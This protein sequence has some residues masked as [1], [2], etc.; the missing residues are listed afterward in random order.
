M[1]ALER[2]QV[3][4]AVAAELLRLGKEL[5]LRLAAVEEGQLVAARERCLGDGAAEEGRPAEDQKADSASSRA[6]TSS[7]VL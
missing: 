6:S 2:T 3:A 1:P 7:A 5:R 4:V